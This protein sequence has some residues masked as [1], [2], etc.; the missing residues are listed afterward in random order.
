V[1]PRKKTPRTL[2]QYDSHAVSPEPTETK[3]QIAIK[4]TRFRT[5]YSATFGQSI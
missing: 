2:S 4:C 5:L 3:P 1:P